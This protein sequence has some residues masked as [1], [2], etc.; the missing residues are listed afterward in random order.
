MV[1]DQQDT[2]VPRHV[3]PAQARQAPHGRHQ[4]CQ[5]V[6]RKPVPE[7]RTPTAIGT[8]P[9]A[10]TSRPSCSPFGLA[11]RCGRG[12]GSQRFAHGGR[13]S[14]KGPE[15]ARDAR[16]SAR[17]LLFRRGDAADKL[18]D[19]LVDVQASSI[20]QDGVVGRFQGG[21]EAGD[22]T[23]V[24]NAQVFK[25]GL[26]A[27]GLAGCLQVGK[28]RRAL[29]SAAAVKKNLRKASGNTMVPWSRPSVTVSAPAANS[30][31][32]ARA[33]CARSGYRRRT[34]MLASPRRFEW[35]P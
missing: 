26:E 20:D 13:G 8:R 3:V 16:R 35:P 1:G 10:V 31:A 6:L 5:H 32:T 22:I 14:E 30:P 27:K 25:H 2:P 21:N 29:S 28:P 34:W 12:L 4:G 23:G 7:P 33:G 18:I 19:H 17:S 9:G 11:G 24:S 15:M